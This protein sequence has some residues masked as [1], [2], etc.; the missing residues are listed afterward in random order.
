MEHKQGICSS[1]PVKEKADR[2]KVLIINFQSIR[3]KKEELDILLLDKHR[4]RL[5][6]RNSSKCRHM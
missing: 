6:I 3:S 4:H 5:R 1:S 2:L